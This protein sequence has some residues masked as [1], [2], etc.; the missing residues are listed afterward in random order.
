MRSTIQAVA[1]PAP[2]RDGVD[3]QQLIPLPE[4]VVAARRRPRCVG[5]RP[6]PRV[7]K[8]K[9]IRGEAF[10]RVAALMDKPVV[11]AAEQEQVA[12]RGL[13]SSCPVANVM[14]VNK[15]AVLTPG[16]AAAAVAPRERSP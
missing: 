10:D 6:V 5:D 4:A 14:R 1:R 9:P 13:A 15:M 12:E 2:V 3:R 16:E 11:T 7:S 8:A